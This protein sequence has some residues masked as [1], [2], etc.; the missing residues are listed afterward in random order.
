MLKRQKC[1]PNLLIFEVLLLNPQM[2]RDIQ[3]MTAIE[4]MDPPLESYMIVALAN[5]YNGYSGLELLDSQTDAVRSARDLLFG[6]LGGSFY[7]TFLYDKEDPSI[8]STPAER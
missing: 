4:A 6:M 7:N 8:N 3:L 5:A 1:I 2:V